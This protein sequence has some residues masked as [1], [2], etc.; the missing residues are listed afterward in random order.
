M[1]LKR[2]REERRKGASSDDDVDGV[3]RAEEEG[4]LVAGIE[5]LA[6]EGS[7][8]EAC[9]GRG[10]KERKKRSRLVSLGVVGKVSAAY[11]GSKKSDGR[12]EAMQAASLVALNARNS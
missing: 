3:L 5:V 2:R 8:I 10:S 1:V 7:A 9:L 4:A 11:A 6:R 12:D